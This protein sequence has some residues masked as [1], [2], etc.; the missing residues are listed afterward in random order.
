MNE[1]HKSV[2][3][4]YGKIL[5]SKNDL[6][7]KS[8]MC[9]QDA[10]SKE[11]RDVLPLVADEIIQKSYGCGSPIPP[12]LEGITLLDLGCGSGRDVFVASKLA[13][14]KG[15][16]IGVDMTEEQIALA[17]SC[18]EK[19]RVIFGFDESNVVFH[20]GYMENL[21][22]AGI[23]DD[24]IDVVISNCVINLSPFK[25]DVFKEIW[26]VLKPGG[27]LIF[28]D[29]FAD[30]RMPEWAA[31]NLT[32]LGECLGGAMY[33]G[34]FRRLMGRVGFVDCR[35]V[36]VSPLPIDDEEI[37]RQI[38]FV[39]FTQ[40]TIRAFKIE[41]LEDACE[42]YGQTAVYDGGI[43]GLPHFFDL[44]D[45]H[46]FFAGKPKLVCGNTAAMLSQSRYGKFFKILGDIA[47]HYGAFDCAEGSS[48]NGHAVNASGQSSACGC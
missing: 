33:V 17:K 5:G 34:D 22:D 31:K 18:Q 35:H 20:L 13:G 23:E 26:R 4:H 37:Y 1:T 7:T 11:V 29:V 28:S 36:S 40:R 44:D 2:Q 14:P 42:D 12:L 46:R 15:L 41:G 16:A 32:L 48:S 3:E 30:R 24:S 8:C 10:Y 47:V 25:E 9:D 38:G 39:S 45:H 27:E 21:R 6:K 19:Q 43:P